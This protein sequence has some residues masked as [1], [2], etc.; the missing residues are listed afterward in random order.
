MKESPKTLFADRLFYVPVMILLFASSVSAVTIALNSNLIWDFSHQGFNFAIEVFRVPLGLLAVC[1]TWAAFVAANHR[2][3]L[4]IEQIRV[5]T[6]QN[7]F[8]N[9]FKH[10]E[11][12]QKYVEANELM[13]TQVPNIRDAHDALYGSFDNF[14]P[15][16]ST[17]IK[18]SLHKQFK[19]CYEVL[20]QMEQGGSYDPVLLVRK[21]NSHTSWLERLINLEPA[22]EQN[23]VVPL[24]YDGITFYY[25]RDYHTL[26]NETARIFGAFEYL[27]KFS[28]DNDKS[29]VFN[30]LRTAYSIKR[31]RGQ[32]NVT[33]L[34]FDYQAGQQA[35]RALNWGLKQAG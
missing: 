12:F 25:A 26:I 22:L 1:A 7:I 10:L 13:K 32:L 2:S 33:N 35:Y 27:T 24:V 28:M 11:E 3:K 34:I 4:T 18:A 19:E 5:T 6:E 21:W 14:Q 23:D 9:Y 20:Y 31:A 16:L 30:A 15:R 17:Q 29:E 8:T